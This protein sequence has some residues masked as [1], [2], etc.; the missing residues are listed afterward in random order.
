MNWNDLR[1]P[2]ELAERLWSAEALALSPEEFQ[3]LFDRVYRNSDDIRRLWRLGGA[4]ND[5]LRHH[6]H[7]IPVPPELAWTLL[8]SDH[9][10]ARVIGLKLLNRIDV[11][12]EALLGEILRAIERADDHE[13]IGGLFELGNYLDR[14]GSRSLSHVAHTIG[15]L[16]KAIQAITIDADENTRRWSS[17][18]LNELAAR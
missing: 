6:P 7:A 2:R 10:E 9:R 1:D 17:H 13:S 15:K 16:R 18:L 11:S 12:D 3:A 4:A 8:R 14:A 5:Y